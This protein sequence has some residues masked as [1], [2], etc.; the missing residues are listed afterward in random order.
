M[1]TADQLK[2]ME[3]AVM[4]NISIDIVLHDVDRYQAEFG[5]REKDVAELKIAMFPIQEQVLRIAHGD[6]P[7]TL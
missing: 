5:L 2:A 1:K 4:M 3:R 6:V 7:S